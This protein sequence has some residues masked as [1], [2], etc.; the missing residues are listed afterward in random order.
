MGGVVDATDGIRWDVDGSAQATDNLL[1]Y[2]NNN[3]AEEMRLGKEAEEKVRL[4]KGA[5]DNARKVNFVC[6][7][8]CSHRFCTGFMFR[9][10]GWV[11]IFGWVRD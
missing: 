6:L 1:Y 4:A 2:Y 7:F 11:G 9:V 8:V 5:E 10:S 3:Q